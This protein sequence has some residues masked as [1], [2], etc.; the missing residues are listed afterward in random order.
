MKIE[1]GKFYRTAENYKVK[2]RRKDANIYHGVVLT[3][4]PDNESTY[5]WNEEG[6]A[7]CNELPLGRLQIIAEWHDI[8]LVLGHRYKTDWGG[9]FLYYCSETTI[10]ETVNGKTENVIYKFL[11]ESKGTTYKYC[12]DLR[13]NLTCLDEEN[14]NIIVE[15]LDD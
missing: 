9:V 11:D 5:H 15:G 6:F 7:F 12:K 1:T 13:G 10:I 2:I 8:N 3:L 14:K 4:D